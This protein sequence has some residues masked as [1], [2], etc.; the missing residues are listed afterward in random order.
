MKMI[1]A[2]VLSLASFGVL[3]HG[4]ERHGTSP[5]PISAE[6]HAWGRQGDP[7]KATRTIAIGMS[8]AM[9]FTPSE[10]RVKQGETVRFVVKNGGK[11]MH[12]MVI[13]T[14]EEQADAHDGKLVVRGEFYRHW[15]I[16]EFVREGELLQ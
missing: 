14:L 11:A 15:P 2:A 3:A 7:K 9:R 16:G 13:G 8:D 10:V 1:A 6:E 12:E 4:P 5:K